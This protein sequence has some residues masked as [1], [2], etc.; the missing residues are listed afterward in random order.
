MVDYYRNTDTSTFVSRPSSNPS[1]DFVNPLGHYCGG[2]SKGYLIS[3]MS[4]SSAV[5]SARILW[6]NGLVFTPRFLR[7]SCIWVACTVRAHS[8]TDAIYVG[9]ENEKRDVSQGG[10]LVFYA[11]CFTYKIRP[12]E[13]QVCSARLVCVRSSYSQAWK[14]THPRAD[15]IWFSIIRSARPILFTV[16]STR[17]MVSSWFKY[18]NIARV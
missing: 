1:P 4:F 9:S 14:L 11:S 7:I 5:K 2:S 10:N 3:G 6:T 16:L 8:D 18:V 13:P 17:V 15:G 12:S